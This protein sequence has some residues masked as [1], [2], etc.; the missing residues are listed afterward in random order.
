MKIEQIEMSGM[1]L[2]KCTYLSCTA[3]I[4]VGD[5]W[6]TIYSIVSIYPNQGHGTTLLRQMQEYYKSNG[7]ELASS[8][9]LSAAMSHL[10]K[11]LSIKE[12]I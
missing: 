11:K 12:Y 10:L 6:A 7:K 3:M 2:D 9:A 4:G 5:N 8:I 1:W